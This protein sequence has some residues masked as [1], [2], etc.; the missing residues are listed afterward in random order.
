[1]K[2]YSVSFRSLD[3]KNGSEITIFTD[4]IDFKTAVR[5][6]KE[7]CSN[8]DYDTSKYVLGSGIITKD[9]YLFYKNKYKSNSNIFI[10]F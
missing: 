9:S 8:R 10:K 4:A 5:Y 7:Y 3:K 2:Y 1:M 6:A